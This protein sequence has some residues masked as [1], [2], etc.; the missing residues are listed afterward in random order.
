MARI[1]LPAKWCR[2]M[3]PIARDASRERGEPGACGA[4]V[5]VAG[6]A[7]NRGEREAVCVEIVRRPLEVTS[8]GGDDHRRL[9]KGCD[10]MWPIGVASRRTWRPWR[11]RERAA[12]VVGRARHMG[13][14]WWSGG[15]RSRRPFGGGGWDGM[16][17]A[18]SGAFREASCRVVG[19]GRLVVLEVKVD[20]KVPLP[21]S[22]KPSARVFT[23]FL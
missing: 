20:T 5:V 13:N 7:W 8:I 14:G 21:Q 18:M 6:S 9:T 16:I 19:R 11:S 12:V 15:C 3:R 10:A 17:D 1:A 4:A 22:H 23:N 2:M